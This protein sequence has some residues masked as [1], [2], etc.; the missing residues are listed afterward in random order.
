MLDLLVP[1]RFRRV[2]RPVAVDVPVID[3][4]KFSI[5]VVAGIAHAA[6]LAQLD[7]DE[8]VNRPGNRPTVAIPTKTSG[9]DDVH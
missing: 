4:Q 9:G 5:R 3:G 6:M 8:I 2:F 7:V 1:S